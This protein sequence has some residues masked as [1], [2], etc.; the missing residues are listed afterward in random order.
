MSTTNADLAAQLLA[1]GRQL[2]ILQE[3]LDNHVRGAAED[4]QYTRNKIDRVVTKVEG[5]EDTITA[6]IHRLEGGRMV[7]KVL[8]I[9]GG[10][11][12][13]IG[14]WAFGWAKPLLQLIA[15]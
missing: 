9:A 12:V 3:R 6:A 7:F 1:Q 11:A 5:I 10:G 8:W 13:A 2:A 4:R 14:A 15:R